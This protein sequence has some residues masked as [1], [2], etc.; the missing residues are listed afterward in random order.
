LPFAP[1]KLPEVIT[2]AHG[3]STNLDE[4]VRELLGTFKRVL[5]VTDEEGSNTLEQ[6]PKQKVISRH[7]GL[8]AV[9][10]LAE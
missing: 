6:V 2:E 10:V 1:Y 9:E 5:V 8:V 3:A 7:S 4:P